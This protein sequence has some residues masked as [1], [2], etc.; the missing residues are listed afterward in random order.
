VEERDGNAPRTGEVLVER[1]GGDLPAP[2]ESEN[3]R[4]SEQ[5]AH[6][7]EVGLG[8]GEDAAEEIAHQIGS[9]PR[10][11]VGEDDARRHSCGPEHTDAGVRPRLPLQH[12]VRHQQRKSQREAHGP[13][14]R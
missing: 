2:D 10:R 1:E 7:E 3:E 14:L 8:D 11:K 12:H 4:H 5:S 13:E 6:H 9:V